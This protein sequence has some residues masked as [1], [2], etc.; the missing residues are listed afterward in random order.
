MGLVVLDQPV[1]PGDRCLDLG[2]GQGGAKGDA[3]GQKHLFAAELQGLEA[4]HLRNLGDRGD[5]AAQ[6]GL[7]LGKGGFAS[8]SIEEEPER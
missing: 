7:D 3:G 5:G 4:V 6:F 8:D 1:D 2:H